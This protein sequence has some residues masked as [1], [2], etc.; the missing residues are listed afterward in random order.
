MINDLSKNNLIAVWVGVIRSKQ[1]P[2][3]E[4]RQAF[5]I[6]TMLMVPFVFKTVPLEPKIDESPIS[7][8]Q[9]QQIKDKIIFVAVLRAG[10]LMTNALTK[11]VPDAH[12]LFFGAK[13]ESYGEAIKSKIY[14]NGFQETPLNKEGQ[15]NNRK[16]FVV[17]PMLATGTTIME[18]L[19]EMINNQ[20]IKTSEIE[21]I[22]AFATRSV[23]KTLKSKFTNLKI[24]VTAIDQQMNHKHYL[25][26]GMGDAGDRGFNTV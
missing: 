1:S 21:I 3:C 17:D 26:P 22:C 13:R 20:G 10:L 9:R 18:V 5:A 16:F 15:R 11:A 2:A 14:Y 6:L 25:V 8:F 12:V 4:I 19:N 24:H 7:S 23:L